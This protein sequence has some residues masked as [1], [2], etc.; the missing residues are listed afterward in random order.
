MFRAPGIGHPVESG[1]CPRNDEGMIRTSYP[2]AR[3][4]LPELVTCPEITYLAP[5]AC[6][7]CGHGFQGAAARKSGAA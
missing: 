3:Q 5:L 6:P 2:E 7:E 1:L 4:S